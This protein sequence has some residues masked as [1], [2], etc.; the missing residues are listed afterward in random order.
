MEQ[1]ATL[2]SSAFSVVE[3]NRR[4]SPSARMKSSTASRPIPEENVPLPVEKKHAARSADVYFDITD[5]V[6]FAMRESKVTGIQRVQTRIVGH[7][8]ERNPKTTHVLFQH[9]ETHEIVATHASGLF[10]SGEFDPQWL[11]QSLG[12]VACRRFPRKRQIVSTMGL[13]GAGRVQILAAQARVYSKA[14]FAPTTLVDQGL[15]EQP[16]PRRRPKV[17]ELRPVSRSE[18]PASLVFLGTNWSFGHLHKF[19]AGAKADGWVV[20]QL[21][22]DLIPLLHPEYC[23][24]STQADFGRFIGCSTEFVSHYLA[25]SECTRRDLDRYLAARQTSIP[26]SVMPL[27]HEFGGHSREGGAPKRRIAAVSAP[28]VLFV[29]TLDRRKNIEGIL[30]AWSILIRDLGDQAPDLVF[31]GRLGWDSAAFSKALKS[32]PAL[33]QKV[34]LVGAP[35]DSELAA[36]YR[37]C[38][39]LLLPSHAEGWGLPVGEAAW[40]GKVSVIT[41]TSSLAE[42]CPSC[43]VMLDSGDGPEIARAVATMVARPENLQDMEARLSQARLRSW[44]DVSMNLENLIAQARQSA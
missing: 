6:H 42:V 32:S 44:A 23:S 12:M 36:L 24:P 27:A 19:A 35:S 21:V 28:Y 38:L 41:G 16:A 1:K 11:L 34:R 40:F 33:S 2:T 10:S 30:D 3:S 17:R 43:S 25:V 8:A 29:G 5:I 14:L 4:A 18:Q 37:D 22:H 26:V 13:I 7:Y 20:M 31:A 9:P 39:C 15:L